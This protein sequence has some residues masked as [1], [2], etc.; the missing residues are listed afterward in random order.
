MPSSIVEICNGALLLL[1]DETISDLKESGT[2]ARLCAN[3][4]D[5]SRDAVLRMHPWNCAVK[6]QANLAP[7][8]TPPAYGYAYAF[9]LSTDHLRLLAVE[10]STGYSLTDYVIEGRKILCDE[11][12]INIR[13]V[14]RNVNISE[15]DALLVDALQAYLA[16]KFAWPLTKSPSVK[17]EMGELFTNIYRLAKS[18]D[19]L[20]EPFGSFG[21]SSPL[22]DVRHR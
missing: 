13:H 12:T 14:Y 9:T 21:E 8:S 16:F 15:Y 6:R 1:G 10:S 4:Y 18:V 20:E 5:S 17:K 11:S 3:L 22:I 19:A 2:R 7:D